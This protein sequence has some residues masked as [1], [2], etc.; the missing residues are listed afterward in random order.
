MEFVYELVVFG[1][2]A[3]GALDVKVVD[4]LGE[5]VT[6]GLYAALVLFVGKVYC[7]HDDVGLNVSVFI[8]TPLNRVA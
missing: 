5:K 7:W 6:D 3:V 4:A 8:I 2:F 1:D